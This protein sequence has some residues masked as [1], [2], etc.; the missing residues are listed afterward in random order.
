M[1]ADVAASNAL[2]EQMEMVSNV[3]SGHPMNYL[4]VV[5]LGFMGGTISG[6]IGSGGA[7]LMTPGMM[8]LGIPGAMAVGANITHKFGKAMVGSRKHGKLGNVD[9]KLGIFLLITA[10]YSLQKR[11]KK[12]DGM[13]I[14]K[15]NAI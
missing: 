7:F 11:T 9:K 12:D 14:L 8:N 2:I 10:F 13:I 3:L 5:L 15:V 6:F 1:L 4:L